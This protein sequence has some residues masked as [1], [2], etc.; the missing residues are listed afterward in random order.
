MMNR[1]LVIKRVGLNIL[2]LLVLVLCLILGRGAMPGFGEEGKR[3]S[4]VFKN[5]SLSDVLDELGR[6]TGVDI[7]SNQ[8]PTDRVITKQYVDESIDDIIKDLFRGLNFALVWNRGEDGKDTVDVWVLEGN[9][10]QSAGIP[11]IDRPA[12]RPS[13]L[14]FGGNRPPLQRVQEDIDDSNELDES[15][16]DVDES[17]DRQA[18]MDEETE[19]EAAESGGDLDPES[20]QDA[21]NPPEDEP[22]EGV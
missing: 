4:F 9:T 18:E 8:V 2:G 22:D 7:I 11:R 15:E 16:E 1:D 5:T 20:A 10:G 14:S 13:P 17:L 3:W 21:N 19:N 6:T 12:Y